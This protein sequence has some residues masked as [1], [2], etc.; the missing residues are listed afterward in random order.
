MTQ[1]SAARIGTGAG[2]LLAALLGWPATAAANGLTISPVVVEI[3]AP[4]QVVSVTVTN[5]TAQPMTLQS[6]TR[7][8]QQVNGVDRYEPDDELLVVPAIAQIKPNASQVFRVTLRRPVAAPVERTYRLVLD[9]I[10]D[11]QKPSDRAAVAF[12]FSH[13]LP[14]MVAPSGPVTQVVRWTLCTAKAAGPAAPS[15]AGAAPA[16]VRLLNAGNRRTKVQSLVVSGDGWQQSLPLKAGE[17]VLAGASRE[18]HVPVPAAQAGP[19][20]RVQV[21]TAQGATLQAEPISLQA[22]R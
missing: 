11:E 20:R 13:N 17:N 10:T 12:K 15:G 16:C 5:R 8:W 4:R 21:L 22:E 6:Q 7:R 2:A 18:W 9:D 3:G 1:R 19:V 14:V